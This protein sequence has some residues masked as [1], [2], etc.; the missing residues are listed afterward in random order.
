MINPWHL[1]TWRSLQERYQLLPSSM[2]LVG[3]PGTDLPSLGMELAGMILCD[4][5]NDEIPCTACTSC[6]LFAKGVHPDLHVI[7]TETVEESSSPKFRNH[8]L[9]YTSLDS[10]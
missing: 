4:K 3:R 8:S 2:L 7:S 10:G 5:N 9:R 1:T 6:H